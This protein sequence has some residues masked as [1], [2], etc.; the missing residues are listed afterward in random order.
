MPKKKKF[1][2]SIVILCHNQAEQLRDLLPTLDWVK[3]L[4]VIDDASSDDSITVAR[5]NKAM[6]ICQA[7]DGDFS[8][9]RNIGL[10]AASQ[11]WV[12]FL[13]ADERLTPDLKDEIQTI[14]SSPSQFE[15][16]KLKRIDFLNGKKITHGEIGTTR[17]VRL[18][19]K[20]AGVWERPIHE[21]WMIENT[22][23]LIHPLHHH[24]H[25]Q[26]SASIKKIAIYAQLEAA[27]R[28]SEGEQPSLFELFVFPPV[29][30]I[31]NF[32]FRLGFLDGWPGLY[33]A[34][35]MSCHSMLHRIYHFFLMFRQPSLSNC[36]VFLRLNL[37]M[38]QLIWLTVVLLVPLGQL[39]RIELN[40]NIAIYGFEILMAFGIIFW[41]LSLIVGRNWPRLDSVW[42]GWLIFTL[43]LLFSLFI[44]AANLGSHVLLASLYFARWLLY[45][46]YGWSLY[47]LTAKKWL[48]P[49][50]QSVFQWWTLGFLVFGF[51][52]YV[53]IP[54]TRF[55]YALGWDDHYYRMIG[56]IFDPGYLGLLLVLGMIA[57]ETRT[58]RWWWIFYIISSIGL[59]LTYARAAYLAFFITV[60]L[61]AW[62]KRSI[63]LL[64]GRSLLILFLL[65][66]LLVLPQAGGEGVNL[67]R[68]YSINHRIKSVVTGWDVFQQHRIWGV[69]FNAYPLYANLLVGGDE[70][71][72]H[73]SSPDSS[74]MLILATTGIIGALAMTIFGLTLY[75]SIKDQPLVLTSMIA[76][77][78]HS[79]TNNSFFYP[80]VMLWFFGLIAQS[81]EKKIT[82]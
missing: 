34:L 36:S 56:T 35:L 18:G 66:S 68:T 73:P 22:G 24:S 17:L 57:I 70:T 76:I 7:L 78:V 43:T 59:V 46:V 39:N 15:A 80:F 26:W 27:Y 37:R 58:T 11:D 53:F 3:Q 71:P 44:N 28:L 41:S 47:D 49:F 74:W 79:F 69:G 48:K 23:Q 33:M 38:Y 50:L 45:S 2:L 54:D 42:Y 60:P 52:Q 67:S 32:I 31:Q 72:H 25:Y 63:K 19:K 20:G 75:F 10:E 81:V 5:S 51:I 16:Y 9:Q 6:V 30:F 4:L 64:F 40:S 13:D 65:G 29:K 62:Q 8:R 21:V 12:L 1:P 82:G 55:L 77:F 14:I 61:L